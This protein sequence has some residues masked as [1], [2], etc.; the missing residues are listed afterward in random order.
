MGRVDEALS[1]YKMAAHLGEALLTNIGT[2][3]GCAGTQL[4][5]SHIAELEPRLA[6]AAPGFQLEA[7]RARARGGSG[8]LVAFQH[9]RENERRGV[10]SENERKDVQKAVKE[11]QGCA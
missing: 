2:P 7:P 10:I 9:Y 8:Y 6:R 11:V 5:Y 3:D 1:R 4:A